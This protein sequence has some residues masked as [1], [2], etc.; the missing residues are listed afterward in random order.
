MMDK[1]TLLQLC[2]ISEILILNFAQEI[3]ANPIRTE[4]IDEKN[5]FSV[6]PR[7]ASTETCLCGLSLQ[8]FRKLPADEFL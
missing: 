2:N 1:L 8:D 5:V 6:H 3:D 4:N 7:E